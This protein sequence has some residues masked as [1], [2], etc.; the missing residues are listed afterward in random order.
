[1][2]ALVA[3]VEPAGQCDLVKPQAGLTGRPLQ[4]GEPVLATALLGLRERNPLLGLQRQ[5]P[6]AKL[7]AEAR[8]GAQHRRRA[9]EHAEE[10]GELAATGEGSLQNRKAALRSG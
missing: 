7:R 4:R 8:V 9:G 1:R 2:L 5:R 3:R 10:V 6:V